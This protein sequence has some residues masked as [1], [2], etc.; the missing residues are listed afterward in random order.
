MSRRNRSFFAP[1]VLQISSMDCGVA[2]L[3]SMLMGYGA[4]ASYDKLRE[5]CQ[6]Q[7][8]GT[9]IDA[10][11][12][13]CLALELDVCQHVVPLDL[14]SH[15]MEG[16]MPLIAIFVRL[17]SGLHYVTVWNRVGRKL[18]IMDP[19]GGRRWMEASE[20]DAE[21]FRYDMRM[22]HQDWRDWFASSSLKDALLA[23][24]KSLLSA[25]LLSRVVSPELERADPAHVAAIDAALRFCWKLVESGSSLSTSA[26]DAVFE[27]GIA[28]AQQ[29]EEGLPAEL[30]S[31]RCTTDMVTTTGAVLL[32]PV[33][34]HDRR[35]VSPEVLAEKVDGLG[36][37]QH[38]EVSLLGQL[39]ALV[40]REARWLPLVLVVSTIA[41]AGASAIEL[42][43]YRASLDLPQLLSAPSTRLLASFVIGLFL[44]L[45]LGLEAGSA[46]GARVLGR[47]I[48]M[49][50]RVRT[51]W[52]LP[53]AHEEF[54]RSRPTSDLAYRAHN[55]G[56]ATK[57]VPTIVSAMQAAAELVVTLVAIALLDMRYVLFVVAGALAFV[58]A[59]RSFQGKLRELDTRLQIHSSRLITF[60]LDALRGIRPIRLHGFQHALRDDH[61]T[62][63]NDWQKSNLELVQTRAHLQAIYTAIG[64]LL[65]AALLLLSVMRGGDPRMF[66]LLA[67]WSFR[68]PPAIKHL[69][70][71]FE[72][73]PLQELA[74]VRVAEILRA[75][76]T[77]EPSDETPR[78]GDQQ[79]EL[80]VGLRFEN[81][82]V[83]AGGH[84][85]LE[86]VSIEIPPGQHVAVVGP[87]GSGK[88]TL[89]SLLLGFHRAATGRILVDGVPLDDAKL[90]QLRRSTA[91][92]DPA[93]HLWNDTIGSNFEYAARGFVARSALDVLTDSDLLSVLAGMDRGLD[94]PM[95][96]DGAFVSGG[97]GVRIRVGR[98]LLRSGTRLAIMDEPFRGLDRTARQ[99]MAAN[100]RRSWIRSTILLV[101][102]DIRQAMSFERVLVVEN[103]RL[104]EDG[105][106]QDLSTR[107]SRF[108]ELLRAED[109]VLQHA[110]SARKWRRLRLER[111]RLSE[112]DGGS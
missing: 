86:D 21:L 6:T 33:S 50:L 27:R 81:V 44:C 78:E 13:L 54:I 70:Q 5:K 3:S 74:V 26:R 29:G 69:I 87:S 15:A 95:G 40:G 31:I 22:P 98:A 104:V 61:R 100:V 23:R 24:A 111:G 47:H 7:I 52:S 55:L 49:T 63:L 19:A 71:F 89:V 16:R 1:E 96:F 91:W 88:S 76:L 45:M 4:A 102:H 28:A 65:V 79:P 103:G 42:L 84:P 39:G 41:R 2:A 92:I 46:W 14:L 35:R 67:F 72:S 101:S 62:E 11:E 73:Y 8:D 82:A 85:I 48:E 9:S 43:L 12:D 60:L 93:V 59:W 38:E 25:D 66:V 32:A 34:A 30:W 10:L 97:E 37:G 105:S 36:L 68:L 20:L 108:A 57:L 58:A 18:Q 94:T 75:T 83:V 17:S 112:V 90:L 53:R 106:P 77:R 107:D 80:G 64:A 109:E 56:L 110:W 99:R 51:L